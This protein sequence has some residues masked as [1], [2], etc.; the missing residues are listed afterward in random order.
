[1]I[2]YINSTP[3]QLYY[4][5]DSIATILAFKDVCYVPGVRVKI[6]TEIDGF[7]YSQLSTGHVFKLTQCSKGMYYFDTDQVNNDKTS[8]TFN[9]YINIQTVKKTHTFYKTGN[10]RSRQIMGFPRKHLL[11]KYN[12][13]LIVHPEQPN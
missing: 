10:R 13:F 7:F 3:L 2:G 11:Y 6:H 4:N 5:I 9:H 1:M 12:R 8:E